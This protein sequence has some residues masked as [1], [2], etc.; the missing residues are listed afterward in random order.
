MV[1]AS[2]LT[3]SMPVPE[4]QVNIDTETIELEDYDDLLAV[5][6]QIDKALV[7]IAPPPEGFLGNRKF[8]DFLC[9]F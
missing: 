1:T 9:I 7:A 4:T 2:V 8:L 5:E 6:N 3:Q